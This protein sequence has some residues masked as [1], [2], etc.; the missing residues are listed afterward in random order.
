MR[1]L[2]YLFVHQGWA[3]YAI[4]WHQQLVDRHRSRGFDVASF[5][6]TPNAPAPRYTFQQLNDLWNRRDPNVVRLRNELVDVAA[7]FD[8]LI[9]FNGAN[10]HPEWLQDFPTFN[11]YICWDDPESSEYLSKP[12]AKYFDF[13]FT[14]N[15]ACVPL[16]NSWGI[17]R[18]EFLPHACYEG[19]Y[20]NNI[21]VDDILIEDRDIDIVF[22]GER[23]SAWRRQRLD[24]IKNA[25]PDAFMRGRGWPEGFLPADQK[26]A[27]YTRSKIGWNIHNSIGPVNIR[28]YALPANGV[29]QIC[30]N[31]SRLGQIYELGK[32]VVGF[33]T[34]DE[35]IELTK[36]YLSH[37]QERRE[38]AARGFERSLRE[39]SEEKQ[40]ER[41]LTAIAPYLELKLKDKLEVPIYLEP[42]HPLTRLK[43]F[44]TG[45][46]KYAIKKRLRRIGLEV[47]RTKTSSESAEDRDQCESEIDT[48]Y[49][50]NPEVGAVN[51]NEKDAR[52]ASG[53][54]FEWPNM[55][56]LNWVVAT[57]VGS[58]KRIVELGGGTG[59]FAY[60]V[61]A[62]SKR[63]ILCSDLDTSAINWAR[64]N[65]NRSNI[66]YVNRLVTPNDGL[67]DLV[68]AID[69]IEHIK[70]YCSFLKS[71][72]EL[73]PQAI[74]TTPNKNR[75]LEAAEASPPKY[76][77]H[78]REWTAGEFYWVLNSFYRSV[79]LFAM[80]DV[81]IPEI[82]P[83]KI[84]DPT[85]PLIAICNHPH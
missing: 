83:I 40:W 57:M 24:Q 14:G 36:Y 6:A 53:G 47:Q 67:F 56:A 42:S 76:Y 2:R 27:A 4:E 13:A 38:I 49:Q 44:F 50:E 22:L 63:F 78:V 3:D 33:D 7:D 59:C 65:R 80:P 64:E 51:W 69:V 29:M 71:C 81:Y 41:I 32:E 5:C 11:V 31:K 58:A 34:I 68:V 55:V 1:D 16:Y 85:T 66:Q 62:D 43:T 28:T 25:F 84:T 79:E 8:V 39:Y 73:A 10:I 75:D 48:S 82:V 37:D 35:C 72:I 52:V 17:K 21:T 46:L 19:E 26:L 15:A 70:D 45:D 23:Q 20:N 18:C 54:F 30:D 60:E 61:S 9:N 77:Q 74:I 12:V